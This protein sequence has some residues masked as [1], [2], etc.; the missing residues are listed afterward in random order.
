MWH[1]AHSGGRPD[2]DTFTLLENQ[3]LPSFRK[4]S[5]WLRRVKH[6]MATGVPVFNTHRMVAQYAES[7]Y[8]AENTV[9]ADNSGHAGSSVRG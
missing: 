2:K 9:H 5:D 1:P 4:R 6:S 3:V 7:M 8:R